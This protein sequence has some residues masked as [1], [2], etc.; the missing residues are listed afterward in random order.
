MANEVL[1]LQK[2]GEGDGVSHAE[3]L[4]AQHVLG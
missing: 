3:G 1:P 4:M 2:K